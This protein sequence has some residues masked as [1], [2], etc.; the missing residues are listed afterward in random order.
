MAKITWVFQDENGTNLNRYIATNV[1]TGE[2]I[3]F[4]LLRG[5]NIS[6]V[7][8]PLNAA[9]LNSLISAINELYDNLS[10]KEQELKQYSDNNLAVA[11]NHTNS[12]I[13]KL[14]ISQYF[15]KSNI[16]YESGTLTITLD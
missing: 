11:Q 6:I 13:E 5:G 14:E 12:E 3:T 4:D 9:N 16:K 7:G 8:T 2:Q 15:K 1:A 10:A